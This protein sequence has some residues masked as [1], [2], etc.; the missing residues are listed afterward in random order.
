VRAPTAP[1]TAAHAAAA[2]DAPA[3]QPPRMTVEAARRVIESVIIAVITSTG[4][5]LVGSVYTE[6]YYGRMSIEAAA[7][8][9]T[10]PYVALQAVHVVDSLLQYPLAL[11]LV[12]L[13]YRTVVTRLPR[14]RSR[15]N[16]LRQRFGRL[17]L[18]VANGLIVSPLVLAAV[19]TSNNP[20]LAQTNSPLSEVA[21]LMELAGTALVVYVLWLSLGRR[22]L[23]LTEVQQRKL[24]P[25]GLLFTLYLLD[26]LVV[27]AQDAAVDAERF[28]TGASD[29][30]VAVVFTMASGVQPLPSADLL[31][32]TIRNG[33]YFVV[34]R[35]PNSPS[36][37]PVAYA[38]PVR[39][40]DA[41]QMTRVNPAA[42][43]QPSGI[44]IELFPTP[45]ASPAP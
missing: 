27:T 17:G 13:L 18:L 23:L 12:Y 32:V 37:M 42:P 11:L 45:T 2:Q 34:E 38:V 6:A 3:P 30:S 7:L 36:R 9:L 26:A 15:A 24:V 41:V 8:D 33:H 16:L 5:Y 39:A 43:S 14:V 21:D 1:T 35:Q 40:V 10:P 31:L 29:S 28:M 19:N 4:L 20:A 22:Q 25:I 44:V